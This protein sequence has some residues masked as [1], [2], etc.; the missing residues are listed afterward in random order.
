MTS[1]V[2]GGQEVCLMFASIRNNLNQEEDSGPRTGIYNVGIGSITEAWP[3]S[4][5]FLLLFCFV[6]FEWRVW[7]YE[8]RM[9]VFA[10]CFSCPGACAI[11]SMHV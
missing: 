5:C 11:N 4:L 3:V 6:L 9:N 8:K 1:R 10:G 2:P 7:R